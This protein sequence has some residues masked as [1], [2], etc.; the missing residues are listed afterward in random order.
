MSQ[1][2]N[3][4]KLK[5]KIEGMHCQSC[6]VL[7]ERKF[8]KV[9]GIE[10]VNVDYAKGEA[11]IYCS[12]EPKIEELQSAI[13]EYGYNILPSSE[14]NA[15]LD[16]NYKNTKNDY[17]QIGAIFLI[18]FGVY[19]LLKKLNLIHGLAISEEMS[20]GFVFLMGL[21]ASVSTCLAV[22]GGL[23]LA[24]A[25]K[26]NES[27]SY[28]NGFQKFK[29][30]I[31]FNLGRI[32][33]YAF[34]GGLVG[35]LGSLLTFSPKITG[36]MTIF[37]SLVM[38]ILGFQLL[39]LFPWMRRFQPK[40]PK[41]LAH[42]I[43]D[44]SSKSNK[45][46]S[47]LLGAST[48]FLPCGFTQ[49]LQL[50][51]LAN[52]NWK[53]G[54]LTMFIFS[55]GTLPALMSLSAISSFIKGTLQNYFLK[56]AGVAVIMLGFF[57]I[58][59]GLAL[60]GSKFSLASISPFGGNELG[61]QEE[62]SANIIDGKQIVE[63]RVVGLNYYPNQFTVVQGIPVEWRIEASQAQGCAQVISVPKLGIV[64]YL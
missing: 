38:I 1:D 45:S 26:Y 18:L 27:F 39:H 32:I 47:F 30:H 36:L 60:S 53:V 54:A 59:N 63:M 5:L 17:F 13:K 44:F 62:F 24:I 42:K 22:T 40:I 20:Y 3:L 52:G 4:K 16:Q 6:E 14:Q 51:V 9:G 8:K 37:A 56:F 2:L 46:T 28:L 55:L 61:Q 41:F 35:A 34:F 58:N 49:A 23:L 31:Y 15:I 25:A 43:Y 64:K 7:I 19:L 10:K 57:N 50:Y 11:E 33:S 21:A 12:K 48:F 29:P